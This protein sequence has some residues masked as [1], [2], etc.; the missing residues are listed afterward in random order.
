MLIRIL[1]LNNNYD[2]VKLFYLDELIVLRKI[3]KFLRSD[4]WATIGLDPI[5]GMGGSYNGP[6]RRKPL[7]AHL[8]HI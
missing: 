8:E 2:M 1:Y 7:I 5:R 4:G 3:K 6:E